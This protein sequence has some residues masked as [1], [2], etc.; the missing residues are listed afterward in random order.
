MNLYSIFL[1]LDFVFKKRRHVMVFLV[2]Y[3]SFFI[4]LFILMRERERW[5]WKWERPRGWSIWLTGAT[6]RDLVRRRM[7]LPI[8]KGRCEKNMPCGCHKDQTSIVKSLCGKWRYTE[9]LNSPIMSLANCYNVSTIT[10]YIN[11]TLFYFFGNTK[12]A[13]EKEKKKKTN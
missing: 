8:K 5:R 6:M 9:H 3:V 11:H 1:S 7:N 12:V 2:I 4:F 13:S 10:L